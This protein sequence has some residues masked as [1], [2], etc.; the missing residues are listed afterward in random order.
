MHGAGASKFEIFDGVKPKPKS[1]GSATL[2]TVDTDRL[3]L[4]LDTIFCVTFQRRY[5][6]SLLEVT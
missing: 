2:D 5:C 4:P 1:D 3:P 6:K